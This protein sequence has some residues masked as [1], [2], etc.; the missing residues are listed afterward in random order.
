LHAHSPWVL[1]DPD[2]IADLVP[3]W[4]AL[5]T[6]TARPTEQAAWSEAAA[7][8]VS[9]GRAL[10]VVGV[11]S[12]ERPRAIAPLARGHSP[13]GHYRQVGADDL[14][15]PAD[16]VYQDA[17]AAQELVETL[18]ALRLPVRLNRLPADSEILKAVVNNGN[19]RALVQVR[20]G[21]GAPYIDLDASWREPERRLSSSRRG[22]LRR[23]RRRAESQGELTVHIDRP[24]PE[25]VPA[26]LDEAF[27]VEA[28]S[29]KGRSKTAL[30]LDARRA[31]FYRRLIASA[32]AAGT[33]VAAF[34]R[35]D[36]R[37]IAMQ[38]AVDTAGRQ[39]VLK[40]GFDEEYSRCS[41]GNVLTAEMIRDAAERGHERYEF[42]GSP[43]PWID[44]WT[45][46]RHSLAQVSLAPLTPGGLAASA[47]ELARLARLRWRAHREQA[48]AKASDAPAEGG[49]KDTAKDATKDAAKDA[50]PPPED[51]SAAGPTGAPGSTGAPGK[52][53]K[54]AQ[55]PGGKVAETPGGKGAAAGRATRKAA[56]SPPGPPPQT[57]RSHQDETRRAA[58][59]ESG[60][61]RGG[62]A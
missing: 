25:Q 62:D 14:G 19:R 29:W 20:P 40:I 59:A 58:P 5:A 2:D 13:I 28:Q 21:D 44:A 46:A 55:K 27:A 45:T 49:A 26:V 61:G 24:A 8:T 41:P 57:R 37:A 12:P 35:L 16:L 54:A 30:A 51:P 6:D 53:G 23:A 18:I 34:L 17:D 22:A 48:A 47:Q 31:A 4:S 32:A 38:L 1:R 9:S 15:E 33:F 10:R 56:P 43:S 52:G 39:W 36:G 50:T 60:A 3:G 42:L 11:G 7:R